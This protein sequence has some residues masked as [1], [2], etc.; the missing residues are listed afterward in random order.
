[1][2]LYLIEPRAPHPSPPTRTLLHPSSFLFFSSSAPH[3]DLHSFPTRRSSDLSIDSLYHVAV[4]L[5]VPLRLLTDVRA[6]SAR[7]SSSTPRSEEHT[8]ELQ[9]REN[10]VCRLLL[11]KKKKNMQKKKTK[12][13]EIT[14]NVATKDALQ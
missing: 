10:L 5:E 11:E 4:A 8:S 6:G 14:H 1:C 9:S 7:C 2:P 3:P 12:H 13:I